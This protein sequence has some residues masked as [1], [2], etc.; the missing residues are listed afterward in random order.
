M[1]IE[2]I[3]LTKRIMPDFLLGMGFCVILRLLK[4]LNVP[5]DVPQ[6]PSKR[7]KELRN[8]R[9]SPLFGV[10]QPGLEPGTSRL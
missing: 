6:C 4:I 9:N 8:L 7:K 3:F 10:D 1:I 5:Q 2:V